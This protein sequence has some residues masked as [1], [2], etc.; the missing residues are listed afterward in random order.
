MGAV[1]TP[2]LTAHGLPNVHK[3]GTTRVPQ[4]TQ[5][6]LSQQNPLGPINA[7]HLTLE[8]IYI[9]LEIQLNTCIYVG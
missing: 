3:K 5:I 1:G 2:E 9:A 8:A 7:S 6:S 4:D